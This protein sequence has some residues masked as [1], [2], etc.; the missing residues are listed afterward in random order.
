[1][2]CVAASQLST[3]SSNKVSYILGSYVDSAEGTLEVLCGS[4]DSRSGRMSS[5]YGT[6]ILDD[7]VDE[8]SPFAERVR[9]LKRERAA[10]S[11]GES[12]RKTGGAGG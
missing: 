4:P 2:C 7:S 9:E 1:M 8:E 5:Q 10:I 12:A 11:D 3:T 6:A